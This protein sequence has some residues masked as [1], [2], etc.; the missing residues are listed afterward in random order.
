MGISG[1]HPERIKAA[2][3]YSIETTCL[4]EGHTYI[5]TKQLII[6]TQ[7][8]LNQSSEGQLVTEMDAANEIIALGENKAIMIEDDRCYFPSLYYA[9]QNVA[10]R[11]RHIASQTEYEDQFP[12]S[13]FLLALGDLEERTKVQY[14]ASQK[15]RFKKRSRPRCFC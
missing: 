9:E 14:A 10:K 15:K 11:V 1:N 6:D 12:E 13:E 3:L 4:S 8:L 2:I 7:K 5:E